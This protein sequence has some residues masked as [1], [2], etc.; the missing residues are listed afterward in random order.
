MNSGYRT[1][2]ICINGHLT[3]D[4][5]EESP[6]STEKFCIKCGK[7]TI[8]RCAECHAPIRGAYFSDGLTFPGY[9]KVPNHCYNCGKSFP[10]TEA[11]IIA[12]KEHAEDLDGLD[13]AEKRQLQTAIDDIAEG[14]ARTELGVS[15]FKRLLGKAGLAI[16]S[17]FYSIVID[18]ASEAAKKALL[19][20]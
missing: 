18:V 9:Y 2:E 16:G 4:S 19:G 17:S 3:T 5:V 6:E 11:R 1:A 14:G 8:R 13:E 10:W 20:P 15:R 7:Q 12:A